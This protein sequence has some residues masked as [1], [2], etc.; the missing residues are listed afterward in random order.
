MGTPNSNVSA[1]R[2]ETKKRRDHQANRTA[3][4]FFSFVE[5]Y[6][7]AKSKKS[8]VNHFLEH[9]KKPEFC[10]TQGRCLQGIGL[11]PEEVYAWMT[12]PAHDRRDDR[13]RRLVHLE[14]TG[15][16]KFIPGS[17]FDEHSECR[18]CNTKMS[19]VCFPTSH[20]I[21]YQYYGEFTV[22]QIVGHG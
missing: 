5:M 9:F 18:D 16:D 15:G 11:S 20:L 7:K 14:T 12:G 21:F 19:N 1:S 13:F 17:R 2:E 3:G 22:F 8:S 10:M 6:W 4:A